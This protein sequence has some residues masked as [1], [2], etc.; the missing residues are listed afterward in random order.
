M[1]FIIKTASSFFNCFCLKS[2]LIEKKTYRP[3]SWG[4]SCTIG[5]LIR[6]ETYS[7]AFHFNKNGKYVRSEDEIKDY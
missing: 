6:G 5:A 3:S 1:H 7:L 4:D 2:L